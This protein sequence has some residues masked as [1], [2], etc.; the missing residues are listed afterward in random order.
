[1]IRSL[2]APGIEPGDHASTDNDLRQTIAQKSKNRPEKQAPDGAGRPEKAPP[3]DPDL[4]KVVAAWPTL[5]DPL[6]AGILAMVKTAGD[7]SE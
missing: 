6:K 2:E 5:P 3:D 7:T 1:M 4:A